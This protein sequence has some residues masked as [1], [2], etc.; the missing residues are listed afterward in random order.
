MAVLPPLSFTVTVIVSG[1]PAVQV[2]GKSL[3]ARVEAVVNAYAGPQLG[4]LSLMPV[5]RL[6]TKTPAGP[7]ILIPPL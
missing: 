3:T 1:A 7:I 2:L 4:S 6:F 5:K